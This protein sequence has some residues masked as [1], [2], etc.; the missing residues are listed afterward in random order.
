MTTW[1]PSGTCVA[2]RCGHGAAHCFVPTP[3]SG[4]AADTSPDA[5]ASLWVAA[6]AAT[7]GGAAAS[8]IDR[9]A[10]AGR[11]RSLP[12]LATVVRRIGTLRLA[13]AADPA[14]PAGKQLAALSAAAVPVESHSADASEAFGHVAAWG[15][16][17][18]SAAQTARDMGAQPVSEASTWT[19]GAAGKGEAGAAL[20][21]AREIVELA[22]ARRRL[23]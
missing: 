21:T 11:Q 22:S 23:S 8:R 5:F 20:S 4:A 13:G 16:L 12:S 9:G 10:R 7:V 18:R 17:H 14:T 6:L 1:C 15:R 19:A 2:P 3:A